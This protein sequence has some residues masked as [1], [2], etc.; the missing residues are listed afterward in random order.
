MRLGTIRAFVI[1]SMAILTWPAAADAASAAT[2]YQAA[3]QDFFNA[4][5]KAHPTFATA[6]GLHDW[7]AELDDVSAAAYAR[8]IA[9][10]KD[11]T[12]KLRAIDGAGLTAMDRDDR[13]ILLAQIDGQLL[14]DETV[15]LWRHDPST[16]VNLLTTAAFQLVERDFAPL[17][18]RM[19]SLIARE[20]RLPAMLAGGKRNLTNIPPVYIDIALANL[21][22]GIS[23]L[24]KDVP[25]A[26]ADVKDAALQKQLAA[27]TKSV[28][29]AAKAFKAWLIAQKP[30]AHG[31]F[32]LGRASL[33]RLLAS[34]M[35]DVP[36]EKVLAAGEAQMAR[37][38]ADFLATA[39]LIDPKNPS[40]ALAEVEADH[41][42]AAHLISTA[43]DQLAALQGFIMQHHI[44]TLP[45]AMLPTVAE[46]PPF[47]RAVIFGQM[48]G[49]GAL[50][51]HATKAYY[52]VTPPD[53]KSPPAQ[54]NQLLSYFNR[55]L[56]QNLSVHE[57]LPGHF[58]QYLFAHANPGWSLVRKTAQ[59]YT[60]TE[61]WAHYT[62]QMMLDE[63]LSKGDPKIKL[64][65]LEDALL[66]DCRLVAS[67]KMHTGRM[68]LDQAT[69]LMET[70]CFQPAA[71]G[72]NEAKR[73][74]SDPGYYSYTLGKLEILKLRSDVQAR[75]GKAFSLTRFHDAFLNA[76]LVPIAIIRREMLGKDGPVL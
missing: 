5:W 48:D 58:T 31:S 43:R 26:F 52:F 29:D 24:G 8:E 53:P 23:F 17:D 66:R 45:S 21:D 70:E 39:K 57:A 36:V 7:D 37:D 25:D 63:G 28:V 42:D 44:V 9:R 68:T 11:T 67:I 38:H 40:H 71:V 1:C 59:S 6:V 13:D 4:Q 69:Q 75:Q 41:P 64:S 12:A 19:R 54:Q 22:G 15:Q 3:V 65:Q 49:P 30:N 35:V 61:G 60:A 34:D 55:A 74:T 33:Q 14:A 47:E 10:L 32:V 46:T 16:Y 72:P 51:T 50:E 2:A 76:G 20:A 27:S 56:L 73:G 62:E 18:Q